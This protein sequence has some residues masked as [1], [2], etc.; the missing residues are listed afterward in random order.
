MKTLFVFVS[1][2]LAVVLAEEELEIVIEFVPDDCQ[3]KSKNGDVL[4][5]H[6]TGTFL[7]GTVFDSSVGRDPYRFQLGAGQVIMGMEQAL[8]GVCAGEKLK[9]TIPSHLAYGERGYGT[10]IPPGN[11]FKKQKN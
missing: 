8:I 11:S 3:I 2:L 1:C 7:D 5:Y 4:T 9:V 6:Y 10:V